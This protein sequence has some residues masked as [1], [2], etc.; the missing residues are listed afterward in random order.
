M[1]KAAVGYGLEYAKD[2]MP[3]SGH[4]RMPLAVATVQGPC[5]LSDPTPTFRLVST[6][7]ENPNRLELQ[8]KPSCR[9]PIV[10]SRANLLAA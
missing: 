8:R 4:S 7:C 10:A 6:H 1:A 9:W 2:E 5:A 3:N